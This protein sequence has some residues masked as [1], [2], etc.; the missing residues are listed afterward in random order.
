MLFF[1]QYSS[2]HTFPFYKLI[3]FF[4][5]SWLPGLSTPP[6]GSVT[7]CTGTSQANTYA[8]ITKI[9][10]FVFSILRLT[11]SL[12]PWLMEPEGSMPYSQVL[13]NNPYPEPNQP[14]YLHWY[15]SL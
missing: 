7:L 14:N 5:L 2:S 3:N 8:I 15:L 12:T 13:S 4:I 11:V 10:D 6:G 1:N 9:L